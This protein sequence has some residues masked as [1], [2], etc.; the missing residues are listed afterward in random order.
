VINDA[1]RRRARRIHLAGQR[2]EDKW[3]L[4]AVGVSPSSNMP[5]S[6]E[7]KEHYDTHGYVIIPGL[8]TPSEQADLLAA[9]NRVVA[10][11]RSGSWPHARVVGK[12]FP[13]YAIGD[14]IW[15]VQHAM[16]S[17]LEEPIF[18]RWYA[19]DPVRGAAKMLLG[20]QDEELQMGGFSST[21]PAPREH[22]VHLNVL[23]FSPE[24]SE[25]FNI[26]VNPIRSEFE[27]FWHRDD[28]KGSVSEDEEHAA[29]T[30]RHYVV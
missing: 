20:C 21:A 30:V 22:F 23:F 14:D 18:A 29:L 17:A 13:P 8:L 15:G 7:L 24:N 3:Q 28:I 6:A 26:L 16:H 12:Q 19:G 9:T 4:R 27:L 11:T 1:A 5:T 25:L 10:R 2:A